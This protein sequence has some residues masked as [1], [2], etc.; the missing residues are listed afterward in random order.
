M[1]IAFL[2]TLE[3]ALGF[4]ISPDLSWIQTSGK[5]FIGELGFLM[6]QASSK[7]N[8]TLQLPNVELRLHDIVSLRTS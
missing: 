6:H 4:P 8:L 5:E 3:A 7:I 1:Y 2:R